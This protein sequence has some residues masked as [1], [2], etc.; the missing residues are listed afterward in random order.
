MKKKSSV[1]YDIFAWREEPTVFCSIW[2]GHS[3]QTNELRDIQ[4]AYEYKSKMSYFYLLHLKEMEKN[5]S[6][7]TFS[8]I[9]QR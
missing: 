3:S 7:W 5:D 2:S 4:S 1:V 6:G 9:I 8:S